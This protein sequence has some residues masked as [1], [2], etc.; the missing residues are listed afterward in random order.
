MLVGVKVVRQG[1]V[2]QVMVL[3]VVV[4]DQQVQTVW[5]LDGVRAATAV[6]VAVATNGEIVKMVAAAVEAVL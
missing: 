3:L 2:V 4:R 6:A 5:V 1:Y